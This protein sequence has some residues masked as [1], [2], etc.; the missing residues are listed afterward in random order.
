M[1]GISAGSSADVTPADSRSSTVSAQPA[2]ALQTILFRFIDLVGFCRE[3]PEKGASIL[4]L[5]SFALQSPLTT[6]LGNTCDLHSRRLA[7]LNTL[8]EEAV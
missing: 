1:A 7:K 4:A 6:A 8:V 2:F 5:V 3:T